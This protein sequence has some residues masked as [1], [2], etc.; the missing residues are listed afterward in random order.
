MLLVESNSLFCENRFFVYLSGFLFVPVLESSFLDR[1][2]GFRISCVFI[3]A[4][5]VVK[6]ILLLLG[7]AG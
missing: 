2:D 6:I 1:N 5:G 3:L 4:V 7:G